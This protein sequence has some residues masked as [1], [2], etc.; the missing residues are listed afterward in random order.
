MSTTLDFW[1]EC[2][3]DSAEYCG[4]KLTDDQLICLAQGAEGAHENYGLAFY[5]P[6]ASDRYNEI[7]REWKTKVAKLEK[8]ADRYRE[9]AERAIK[10]A[11]RQ[12]PDAVVSIGEYGEVFRHGGRT[13]QIQ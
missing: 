3:S 8:D 10:E 7:E 6:P 11:L 13:D 2:I 4:L 12:P 5:S 1:K 9:N